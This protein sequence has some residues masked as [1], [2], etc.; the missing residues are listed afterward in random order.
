MIATMS[1]NYIHAYACT[2]VKS[3]GLQK[4]FMIV[5]LITLLSASKILILYQLKYEK[6]TTLNFH[7][8]I[9][10]IIYLL[11]KYSKMVTEEDKQCYFPHSSF[12]PTPE[13]L[14]HSGVYSGGKSYNI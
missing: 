6:K 11:F 3:S 12:P 8:R 1:N 7:L 4:Q 9:K 10:S 14:L 13:H 5:V 2:C